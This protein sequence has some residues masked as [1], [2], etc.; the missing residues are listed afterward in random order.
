M[1]GSEGTMKDPSILHVDMDAFFVAVEVLEDPSL[2]GQ[3]V[4]V[5]GS[6]ARGVVA[7]C[8]YE[9]RSYGIRSAMPS[10]RARRLCP[11]AVFVPGHYELYHEHSKRLH[12]VLTS[13]TPL[14]EGIA[15]DEAFLDVTGSRRLWGD[16]PQIGAAI[17]AR[18]L[19]E[20]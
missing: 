16:G 20:T 9:A 6:G 19:A 3:P 8:S 15:L 10:M 13:F 12:A 14:V 7:S 2:A 5:G 1:G 4:I 11:H 18:V 17:R